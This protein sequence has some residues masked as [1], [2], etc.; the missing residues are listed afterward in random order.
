MKHVFLALIFCL[1]FTQGQTTKRESDR[2]RDGF[3][4]PVKRVF[5]VWSPISG[6]N[7]PAGSRC[8]SRTKVY[9]EGGRLVQQSHYPGPCGND[10]IRDDYTYARDGS[11]TEKSQEIRGKDS[12]TPP[13]PRVARPGEEEEL[14]EKEEPGDPRMV[15]KYNAAGRLIESA[16]VTPSGKIIYKNTYSYD[17]MG[18][19]TE[20]TGYDRQGQVSDRHVYSYSGD[21][22][23]P[24]T[25]THH[26]RD[27]KVY[28]RT[29]YSDYE[30]N[31]RGDWIKRKHTREQRFNRRSVSIITREIE[32][33]QG[34]K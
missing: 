23:V 20:L 15:F 32:Y 29:A 8:R 14:G 34:R 31:E 28:D 30:F 5:E 17:D 16:S 22:R 3:V 11:R 26:G 4:G 33:Y 24:S 13:P 1:S 18:R 21:S 19:M 2:E 9:D 6:S 12:P 27:D 10:E 7:Y 25:S